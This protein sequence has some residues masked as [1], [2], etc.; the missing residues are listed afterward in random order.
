MY[1]R[2]EVMKRR[3]LESNKEEG[4]KVLNKKQLYITNLKRE[5]PFFENFESK[6]DTCCWGFTTGKNPTS[7]YGRSLCCCSGIYDLASSKLSSD[8]VYIDYCHHFLAE[9]WKRISSLTPP[10]STSISQT[11]IVTSCFWK[12]LY[13]RWQLINDT[14]KSHWKYV[15]TL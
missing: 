14:L 9:I 6:E 4:K 12:Y 2:K 10:S 5:N 11:G 15:C 7:K 8:T 13:V 3:S 1:N